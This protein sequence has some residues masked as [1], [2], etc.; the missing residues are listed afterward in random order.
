PE[1]VS[2]ISSKSGKMKSL[3]ESDLESHL[4]K[5]QQFLNISKPFTFEG[6]GTLVKV[7]HGEFEFNQGTIIPDKL[8]ET[9]E[10]EVHGV[11]KKEN[12]DAKYQAYLATP[13]SK[14]RWRKP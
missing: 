8:K 6:I 13:S 3:A 5:V 4:Q 10:K 2:Y 11:T 7:K 12:V 1:L 14:S 9:I